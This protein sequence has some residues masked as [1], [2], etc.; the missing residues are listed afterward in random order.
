MPDLTPEQRA[1]RARIAGLASWSG[2]VDRTQRTA[3]A[4]SAGPGG[5]D[6]HLARLPEQFKS[7]TDAQ[8]RAAAESARKLYF[9]RIAYKSAKARRKKVA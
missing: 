5:L 6:Y 7:A 4:R 1:L 9:Q 3:R 2:T 8:R